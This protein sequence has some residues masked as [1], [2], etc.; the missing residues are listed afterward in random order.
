[1]QQPIKKANAGNMSD[2]EVVLSILANQQRQED[3]IHQNKQGL[4]NLGKQLRQFTSIVN[5]RPQGRL[6]GNTDLSPKQVNVVSTRNRKP[7]VELIPKL[8]GTN[9]STENDNNTYTPSLPNV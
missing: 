2:S 8:S 4:K 9:A 3:E 7:M 6:P 5:D 1:M